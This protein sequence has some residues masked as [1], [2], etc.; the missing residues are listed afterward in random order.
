MPALLTSHPLF[1][2]P[3]LLLIDL[4]LWRLVGPAIRIGAWPCGWSASCC[5]A[6]CC[7]MPG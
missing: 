2:A 3:I 6:C 5:S 7:S 4:L 1:A